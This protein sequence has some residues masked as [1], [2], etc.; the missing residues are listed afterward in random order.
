MVASIGAQ[1]Y[2][3]HDASVPQSAFP[4]LPPP[5]QRKNRLI[6]EIF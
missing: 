3:K 1:T 2:K 4:K 6:Q 5:S